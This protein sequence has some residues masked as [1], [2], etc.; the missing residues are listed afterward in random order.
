MQSILD[1][2]K[3]CLDKIF[4]FLIEWAIFL[5]QMVMCVIAFVSVV[6]IV[7]GTPYLL[8]RYLPFPL[9][10]VTFLFCCFVIIVSTFG[11][12]ERDEAEL[13]KY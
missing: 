8:L 2:S 13:D 10:S 5:F 6:S 3:R 7:V 1:T 4:C 12:V 11:K 9:N